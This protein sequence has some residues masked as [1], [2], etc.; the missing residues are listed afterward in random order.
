[1]AG[2]TYPFVN[3]KNKFLRA[4]K[5]GSQPGV[6][7]LDLSQGNWSIDGIEVIATADQIN[8]AAAGGLSDVNNVG[9]GEGIF[10]DILTGTI[11][12]KSLTAGTN[13]ALTPSLDGNEIEITALGGSGGNFDYADTW[14]V[15]INGNDLNDGKSVNTPKATLNGAQAAFTSLSNV[16]NILDAGTYTDVSFFHEDGLGNRYTTINAPA[17]VFSAVNPGGLPLF[18]VQSGELFI[19]CRQIIN[20]ASASS[21]IVQ[22][23]G[24]L[25]IRAHRINSGGGFNMYF[26]TG[27]IAYLDGDF[28]GGNAEFSNKVRVTA[29]YISGFWTTNIGPDNG[30]LF[31][32]AAD[33]T[34]SVSGAGTYRGQLGDT[35]YGTVV[36]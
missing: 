17:A 12:L 6:N 2:P 25:S 11:N 21:A 4:R 27:G 16:I 23:G 20:G 14:F 22:S 10:K 28:I 5:T 30:E 1:M 15:A 32:G 29:R 33:S 3:V 34:A 8:N 35:F 7:Q 24:V 19:N 31:L 36:P 18:N 26:G 13:I 9:A